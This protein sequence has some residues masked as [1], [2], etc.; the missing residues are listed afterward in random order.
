[1][2]RIE[3]NLGDDWTLE[4]LAEVAQF[5]PFHF[6]RIFLATTG[7]TLNAFINRVRLERAAALLLQHPGRQITD[8]AYACGFGS[9]S[10]FT[11]SFKEHYDVT[12]SLWRSQ[13]DGLVDRRPP[14]E[15][16]LEYRVARTYQGWD[17][18]WRERE[19]NKV[20]LRQEEVKEVAYLRYVGPFQGSAEVFSDLFGQLY[21]WARPQ[22]FLHDD[23]QVLAAYHD[24]PSLTEDDK[25][26]V[27]ACVTVPKE[28]HV[29]GTVGRMRFP[30][31]LYG[32]GS[33]VLGPDE[34]QQAWNAMWAGWLPES[35]YEPADGLA[36]ERFVNPL[37]PS[38]QAEVEICIPVRPL[39]TR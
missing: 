15:P 24:N 32:V 21:S 8:V 26:R 1:M 5:S 27:S 14:V 30:G 22:G 4:R 11:R 25:L 16:P 39:R 35:G 36:F 23:A 18:G 34:Y 3:A 19:P 17:L 9:P 38:E 29:C 2:D 13:K 20:C 28:T 10:S 33:F 6:H 37:Q 31:G 12:P 7:E